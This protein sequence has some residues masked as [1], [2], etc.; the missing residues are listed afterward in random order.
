MKRKLFNFPWQYKE[1]FVISGILVILG[2]TVGYF[3]K[4]PISFPGFP[5]NLSIIIT[6]TLLLAAFYKFE[7]NNKIIQW[8][9]S[10]PAAITS[11][12][13]FAF[14]S[15]LLGFFEQIEPGNHMTDD[16]WYRLGFTHLTSSWLF[17]LGYVY[18]TTALGFATVKMFMP[19]KKKKLGILFSHAGLYIIILTGIAG[20]GDNIRSY[21]VLG[22]GQDPINTVRAF[23]SE[24]N[25]QTPF[26]LQLIKFDIVEYNP[27]IVLVEAKTGK[28]I[29][30]ENSKHFII[31]KGEKA[32]FLDWRI[33]IK[34]LLKYSFPTD[35][36]L[37]NFVK[38]NE[39]PALPSAYAEVYDKNNNL[40]NKDWCSC[41]NFALPRKNIRVNEDYYFA[42]LTPEPKE[43]SSEIKAYLPDGSNEYF[44]LKVN[45]PKTI[46]GWKLYQTGYNEQL[47]KWSDYSIIEAGHDPWLPAV[48]TGIFILIAGALYI[49]WLGRHHG[50]D[51]DD[52]KK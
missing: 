18:F 32:V 35:T 29:L 38:W 24:T 13:L 16:I 44:T 26:K 19:F 47:G 21:F 2:L 50:K 9:S 51:D 46:S 40:I 22:K 4:N 8:F 1:G 52:E 45:S 17:A 48:Y 10:I 41:G 42:M 36:L 43:F 30:P 15:A 6:Y 33:E 27:K 23:N 31:E 12:L 25:Y 5:T 49:F 34:E 7:R 39:N 14:L 3:Y 11:T 28:I 37:S 20:S